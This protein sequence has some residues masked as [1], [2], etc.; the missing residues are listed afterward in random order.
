MISFEKHEDLLRVKK[1]EIIPLAEKKAKR[2]GIP[3]EWIKET[4][5][6]PAQVVEG[7]GGRKVAHNKFVVRN[8]EYLL[9]VV[10]EEKK[11]SYQVVTAYL[12]SQ[13]G[14]YWT[15]EAHEN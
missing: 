14:R 5:Q 13:I 6:F 9:R 7:Y 12:T 4:I 11:N 10:Y 2:R 8:S 1:I 15:E 3:Q